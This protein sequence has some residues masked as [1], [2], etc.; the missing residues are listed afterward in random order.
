MSTRAGLHLA[1]RRPTQDEINRMMLSCLRVKDAE[2]ATRRIERSIRLRMAW[3]RT[4]RHLASVP[5]WLW[6]V[7]AIV[8][9]MWFMS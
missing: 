7:A 3:W 1:H 9:G 5:R 2:R 8:C 4:K 6:A